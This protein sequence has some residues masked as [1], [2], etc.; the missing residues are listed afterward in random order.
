MTGDLNGRVSKILL[1]HQKDG[2]SFWNLIPLGFLTAKA[3]EKI[4]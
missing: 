1:P 4:Q 2:S 3:R